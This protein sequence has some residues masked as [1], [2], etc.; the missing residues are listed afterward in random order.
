MEYTGPVPPTPTASSTDAV[1]HQWWTYQTLL[2]NIRYENE[3]VQ[4]AAD[5]VARQA[6]LDA[7]HTEKMAAEAACAAAQRDVAKAQQAMATAWQAPHPGPSDAQ[8]LHQFMHSYVS[9]GAPDSQIAALAK[10]RLA[11]YRAATAPIF[12]AP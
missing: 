8:M 10:A 6:V 1:W 4:S 12:Q 5:A 2:Q 9:A 3:R 7:Q 11:E